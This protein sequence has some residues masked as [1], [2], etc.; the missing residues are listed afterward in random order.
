MKIKIKILISTVLL[1]FLFSPNI[2]AQNVEEMMKEESTQ[3]EMF[4]VMMND[5]AMMT[6]FAHRLSTD[7]QAMNIMMREMM[8]HPRY[9]KSMMQHM[10]GQHRE[11]LMGQMMDNPDM[12]KSMMQKMHQRGMM[13]RQ[14]MM[15]GHDMMDQKKKDKTDG[16]HR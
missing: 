16:H 1:L 13:D 8:R 11:Q 9:R 15:K 6:N 7:E 5:E 10:M 2:R 12:M 14:S 4:H 3:Q